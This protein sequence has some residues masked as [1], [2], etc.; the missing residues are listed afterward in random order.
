MGLI[1]VKVEDRLYVY[2]AFLIEKKGAAKC[3]NES[4]P[5][6][7]LVLD[8]APSLFIKF[9]FPNIFVKNIGH[10]KKCD[11]IYEGGMEK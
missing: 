6:H 4:R 9:P 11:Y 1:H 7:N 10:A 2:Q 3:E 8:H 5:I